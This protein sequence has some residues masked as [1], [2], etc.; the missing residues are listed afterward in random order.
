MSLHRCSTREPGL[1]VKPFL[2]RS[3]HFS[4][5][6][7][8]GVLGELRRDSPWG[9]TERPSHRTRR[10]VA[11]TRRHPGRVL[12]RRGCVCGWGRRP[13]RTCDRHTRRP[14]DPGFKFSGTRGRRLQWK[15]RRSAGHLEN[16][17]QILGLCFFLPFIRG[18]SQFATE[19]CCSL[20]ELLLQPGIYC[21]SLEQIILSVESKLNWNW[22]WARKP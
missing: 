5:R 14:L 10:S 18:M 11:G 9:R 17:E 15:L 7:G 6:T 4:A 19:I 20:L 13:R 22:T 8:C 21:C 16:A 3:A 2:I 1:N 12:F